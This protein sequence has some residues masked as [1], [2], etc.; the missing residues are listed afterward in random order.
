[1]RVVADVPCTEAA[2][3]IPGVDRV[4]QYATRIA[5]CAAAKGEQGQADTLPLMVRDARKQHRTRQC[6]HLHLDAETRKHLPDR[7]ANSRVNDVSIVRAMDGEL[8]TLRIACF[9]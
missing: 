9:R 7:L 4:V 8:E 5:R 6:L 2:L 1:T 3:P